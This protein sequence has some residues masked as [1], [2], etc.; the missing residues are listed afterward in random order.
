[1]SL[2][3][4]ETLSIG[5]VSPI[6]NF[7]G[8]GLTDYSFIIKYPM[9]L[10]TV[11]RKLREDKYSFVEEALDDIQ[12]IWDNCKAYNQSGSVV[13]MYNILVDLQHSR[14]TVKIVQKNGQ[15]LFTQYSNHNSRK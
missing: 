11:S 13:F 3:T 9:D 4:L 2:S 8:M 14:K 10:S 12:L 5:K 15:K 7:I 6:V 1:M